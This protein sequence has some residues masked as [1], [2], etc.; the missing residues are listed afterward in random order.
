M[1][2]CILQF[3]SVAEAVEFANEQWPECTN[4]IESIKDIDKEESVNGEWMCV[5]GN[6]DICNKEQVTFAPS[7]NYAKE[8]VG[9]E[10][11]NCGNFSVYPE[12]CDD[13]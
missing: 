8:I 13:E 6:C 12:E 3:E 9:I 10:C 1:A 5:V 4:V 11:G 7:S 2:L